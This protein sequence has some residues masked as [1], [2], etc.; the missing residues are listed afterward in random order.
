SVAASRQLPDRETSGP[1]RNTLEIDAIGAG[2]WGN[3]LLVT[4]QKGTND[5]IGEFKLVIAQDTPGNIVELFDNLSMDPNSQDYVET[6]INN[7][8][9]FITVKDLQALEVSS[10]ATIATVAVLADPVANIAINDTI[11]LTM[12]DGSTATVTFPAATP[13]QADLLTRLT[14]T[15]APLNV[16][17]S[18]N[19]AGNLVLTSNAPGY[20]KYFTVSGTAIVGGKG[21][22]MPVP[23]FAQGHGPAIPALLKSGLEPFNIPAATTLA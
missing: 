1:A 3:G 7:V 6:S 20:D 11:I 12:Q 21:W 9:D 16:S 5:P 8:S 15:F 2:A 23:A 4:V 10:K 18:L 13:A 17:V 22:E 19:N 14:N